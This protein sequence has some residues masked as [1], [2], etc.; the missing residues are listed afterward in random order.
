MELQVNKVSEQWNR[1]QNPRQDEARVD[2]TF[3]LE[4]VQIPA[5]PQTRHDDLYAPATD[6]YEARRRAL[7][8]SGVYLPLTD[9]ECAGWEWQRVYR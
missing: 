7:Y 5:K 9:K 4:R 3:D 1:D 2:S 6:R 8:D